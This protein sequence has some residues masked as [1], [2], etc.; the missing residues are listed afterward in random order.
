M[1]R[2]VNI[3]TLMV[4]RSQRRRELPDSK[5]RTNKFYICRQCTYI[6]NFGSNLI[7]LALIDKSSKTPH[8]E[9]TC[10]QNIKRK[11]IFNNKIQI[12]VEKYPDC[13]LK[14]VFCTFLN[15]YIL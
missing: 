9:N 2:K 14:N 12:T 5:A 15:I 13:V 8:I 7:K 11:F 1:R 4:F 3:S 10:R 6:E